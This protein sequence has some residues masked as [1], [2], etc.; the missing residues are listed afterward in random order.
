MIAYDEIKC[1][2]FFIIFFSFLKNINYIYNKADCMPTGRRVRKMKPLLKLKRNWILLLYPISF[3]LLWIASKSSWAAEYLFARGLFRAVKWV[4]AHITALFP[5]SLMEFGIVVIPFLAVAILL[6]FAI[7]LVR[8]KGRRLSV[9]LKGIINTLCLGAIVIFLLFVGCS[10]NY[11]RYTLA[12]HLELT[13]QPAGAKE[14]KELVVSLAKEASA[15]REELTECEDED[16]VYRLALTKKELGQCAVAAM[17]KLALGYPVFA[18]YYP[19]PKRIYFSEIMSRTELTGVFC[20]FTMEANVNVD[21]SD[22][23]IG[24]TMCHELAHLNGFIREDEANYISYLAAMASNDTE[25]RYSGLMEALILSGNALYRKNPELYMEAREFYS[26]GVIRDLVANSEYW[27]KYENTV[28]S[29]TA[30]K[31]NDTYL[32]ANNQEDGV[33]SYGRMV[34]LLL[35]QYRK[36]KDS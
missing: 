29:N 22:Y 19:Q 10:V 5:F 17:E 12:E 24:S 1:K 4:M 36:E 34:D 18:G 25:L 11:Y 35:A 2:H 14:L 33:Q 30:E 21:I 32:K 3:L 23:S 31:L 8:Q 26:D 28:V 6:F 13:I 16:G 7:H 15:A 20:P 9:F 27:K